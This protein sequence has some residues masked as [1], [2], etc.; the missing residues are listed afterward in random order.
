M[1]AEDLPQSLVILELYDIAEAALCRLAK[2]LRK[3]FEKRSPVTSQ[4]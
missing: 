3:V 1:S 2:E 4:A